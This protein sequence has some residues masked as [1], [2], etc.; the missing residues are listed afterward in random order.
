MDGEIPYLSCRNE[1][2]WPQRGLHIWDV[3]FE[4]VEG[5]CDAGL[6]FRGTLPRWARRRNL[7]ESGHDCSDLI[8]I[9]G[10]GEV[11]GY[12]VCGREIVGLE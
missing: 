3:G 2:Q 6:E 11:G 8:F 10:A 1:L 9:E 7:V 12:A 4:I 5:I